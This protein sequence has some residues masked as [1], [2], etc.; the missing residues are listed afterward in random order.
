MMRSFCARSGETR[1]GTCLSSVEAL[2]GRRR[3]WRPSFKSRSRTIFR[4]HADEGQSYTSGTS[5]SGLTIH[6]LFMHFVD[7]FVLVNSKEKLLVR[8]SDHPDP[9]VIVHEVAKLREVSWKDWILR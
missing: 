2:I 1:I 5:T 8:F 4:M 9:I 6:G 7:T 3:E